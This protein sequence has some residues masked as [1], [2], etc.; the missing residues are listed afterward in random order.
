MVR[1]P[2]A[3]LDAFK[4]VEEEIEPILE[5]IGYLEDAPFSW[6]TLAIRY[7]LKNEEKPH[8]M[9]VNKK[10]GDL[11]LSIEVDVHEM[12][13]A[14]LDELQRIFRSAA[15]RALIHAGERYGRP[16]A[17]LKDLASR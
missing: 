6:V 16:T 2:K 5:E 1:V 15:L 11:P 8:Y 7:G 4:A 13:G 9:A 10:Y 17:A 14:S 12:L 3:T